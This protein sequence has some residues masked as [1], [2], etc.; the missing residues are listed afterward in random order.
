MK[1][2]ELLANPNAWTQNAAARDSYGD[3]CHPRS[4]VAVQWCLLGAAERCYDEAHFVIGQLFSKLHE[5]T[6]AL[7]APIVAY[8]DAINRT[9][10]EILALITEL[11]I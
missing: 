11:D 8:N 4:S 5:A 2:K 3:S 10:A 7:L 1:I 6:P 9:H